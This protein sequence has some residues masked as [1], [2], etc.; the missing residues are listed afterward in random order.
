MADFESSTTGR[1]RHEAEGV[2]TKFSLVLGIG[3][4]GLLF[5]RRY[6]HGAKCRSL[7]QL[8]GKTVIVTG[9]NTGIGK[10]TALDLA[11]RHARVILA[12]RDIQKATKGAEDIRRSTRS[13]QLVVKHLDLASL[14][15]IREFCNDIL[16]T[17]PRL[18]IL[19]NNAG[20]SWLPKFTKTEDGLEMQMGVNHFGHF[21]LT[22][23]LLGLLKKSS[24]GA[25]IVIV[26]SALYKK[27]KIDF[28]NLNSEKSYNRFQAY[29]DSKLSNV[30]FGQELHRR[31][32]AERAGVSVYTLHPGVVNSELNRHTM[33]PFL[34]KFFLRP[35]FWLFMKT[36]TQG[37]QTTIYCAVAGE[38][39]GLSGLY[40]GNCKEHPFPP[41]ASLADENI[42][43]KLWEA[44]ERLT[45]LKD[46]FL[47]LG[48]YSAVKVKS[49]EASG[50]PRSGG[51]RI[52]PSAAVSTLCVKP[53][54]LLRGLGNTSMAVQ[55]EDIAW[56][57]FYA[58]ALFVA[59]ILW[60]RYAEGGVCYSSNRMEGRTVIVTGA[61]TG[62]GKEIAADMANRGAHVI[63]A[64]RSLEKGNQAAKDIRRRVRDGTLVVRQL[65]LASLKSVRMFCKAFLATEPRL[66]VLINNAGVFFC[67]YMQTEDGFENHFGVNHLGHFLLTNQLL[68]LLAKSPGSRVVNVSS[69]TYNFTSLDFDNLNSEHSYGRLQA[70]MRSKL[71]NV[72]FSKELA[73]R[74]KDSG[75]SVYCVNPGGVHTDITR[76]LLPQW[77]MPICDPLMWLVIKSPRAGA[78]TAIHCAVSD[79]V[80]G[81]S[82]CY[83][84]DCKEKAVSTKG[85]DEGKAKKLWEVSEKMTGL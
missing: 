44:S 65:D 16:E 39:E 32:E 72:L 66:D 35:L 60:K 77:C 9:A 47:G 10:A 29:Y 62:M 31:L 84:S 36:P 37:A 15:S 68:P 13:E 30:L 27:G 81:L 75:V 69:F 42:A 34:L 24:P 61:N 80:K 11:R 59:F 6:F 4:V 45:G 58:M 43:K 28:S 7:A 20:V 12:C 73:R 17:E 54:V 22:N 48:K 50:K 82:G 85:M 78:Q 33:H 23:R 19:I 2:W 64:C 21:L 1:A 49:R 56:G 83:F 63:M 14:I 26:S 70:Y 25:R 46:D 52:T 38:L 53:G 8:S 40:Y 18:D 3:T 74:T 51:I 57:A 5:F 76:Y 67:P 71:A 79:E 41:V 55:M